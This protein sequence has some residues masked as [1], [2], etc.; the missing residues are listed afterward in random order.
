ME[1]QFR[2]LLLYSRCEVRGSSSEKGQIQELL[3]LVESMQMADEFELG[4]EVGKKREKLR[5]TLDDTFVQTHRTYTT[6]SEPS[7]KLGTLGSH[8]MS[9]QVHRL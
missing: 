2:K 1:R 6:K 8:D 5:I 3:L 9:V 4:M 7:F